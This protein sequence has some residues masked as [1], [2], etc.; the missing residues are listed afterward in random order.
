MTSIARTSLVVAMRFV[1]VRGLALF[2]LGIVAAGCRSTR[3]EGRVDAPALR[4]FEFQEPQ[5]GVPFRMVLHARDESQARDAAAA[6]F[7]RVRELNGILS[8]YDEA[9]E[10]SRLSRSS[11]EQTEVAVSRD[12]W[13]VLARAEEFSRT[14]DGAFDVTVGPLVQQW[15]RARRQREIPD[16]AHM[17]MALGAI[18]YRHLVLDHR[19]LTARLTRPGM[20]LDLGAIAKGYAADEALKV[21]RQRGCSRA[22]VAAA[23]DMA[24]GDAPPGQPGW[25]IRVTALDTPG[26]PAASYVWIV[27]QGLSTSG[28]LFQRVEIGGVRYSHIVDPHTGFGIT[29]HSLVT[30]IAPDGMTADALSTSVSVLG[31]VRGLSYTESI[32]GAAC[33]VVR[34]PALGK[35]VQ[36]LWSRR[37][38]RFRAP[39]P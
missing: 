13:T 17:Q 25:R 24:A 8:D 27:N 1:W 29:D 37:W 11:A 4:R 20:R 21:L 28:D 32:P 31:P 6:A 34:E 10:L 19:R 30:V 5:M 33:H 3:A 36:E 35:P 2:L 7:A 18:G 14:T 39:A 9:S 16:R 22:L 15:K 38:D 12:L 23:G 26:A